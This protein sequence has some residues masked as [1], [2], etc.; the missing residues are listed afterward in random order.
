MGMT[1]CLGTGRMPAWAAALLFALAAWCGP[2]AAQISPF[3]QAVA[4]AAA[5]D[6]DIAAFYRERDYAPIW[7]GNGAADRERLSALARA[8]SEVEAH[9]LPADRHAP[10][11]LERLLSGIATERDRGRAEVE[12]SRAFLRYAR[13]VQTGVLVPGEIDPEIKREVPL[14][15]R[16]GLLR[17]FSKSTPA[18]FQ[19]A[20]PPSSPQYAQLMKARIE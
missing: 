3:M 6:E 19:R 16:E 15:S 9:G 10:E 8:L 4:E 13:D 12:I 18:A 17:A 7:T 2:A 11:R 14:R 1:G 20:L 5:G